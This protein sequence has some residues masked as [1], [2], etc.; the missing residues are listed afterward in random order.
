MQFTTKN[1][2]VPFAIGSSLF[3]GVSAGMASA[4]PASDM[5]L[6]AREAY[7]ASVNINTADQ[8]D[9]LGKE[10]CEFCSILLQLAHTDS[11]PARRV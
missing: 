11:L 10:N 2:L 5:S 4:A 8:G 3:F 6:A 1:L 7:A 9:M